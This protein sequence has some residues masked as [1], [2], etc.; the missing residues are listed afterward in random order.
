MMTDLPSTAEAD[1]LDLVQTLR[2]REQ[3][4]ALATVVR[5]IA[6]TAAKA[7]AKAVITI[8]GTVQA[9]WIG[10]GCARGAVIRAARAALQDGKPRLISV[11]P[12][13]VLRKQ[14]IQPGESRTNVEF[15]GSHCPS[16]G[17]MDIFIEPIMPRRRL[18]VFGASPVAVA[19]VGLA[20]RFR[21]FVTTVSPS[22]CWA[23]FPDASRHVESYASAPP[24]SSDLYAVVST[25]GSGDSTALAEAMASPA[26]C[27]E[28]VGSSA[29]IAA[30]K[31]KLEAEGVSAER[32]ACLSGPAGIDIGAIT[33]DEIAL[34]VLASVIRTYRHGQRSLPVL[35]ESPEATEN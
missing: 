13:D 14:D 32:L 2:H 34:S 25:Q 33:P 8:D 15:A 18:V 27:V 11:Q 5:T 19:L 12:I 20:A 31:I 17:T 9:G 24:I 22:E 21:F 7:G 29:K 35:L 28:F 10:G 23:Q 30:L 16:R 26:P 1:I 6:S 3:P 4:F